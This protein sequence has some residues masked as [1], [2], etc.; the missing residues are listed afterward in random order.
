MSALVLFILRSHRARAFET[1]RQ[2][3]VLAVV[4]GLTLYMAALWPALRLANTAPA[5]AATW[6]VWINGP[7]TEEILS[8]IEQ[9]AGSDTRAVAINGAPTAA[10]GIDGTM[11]PNSRD[12]WYFST[13]NIEALDDTPWSGAFRK[14]GRIVSTGQ[15]GLDMA[16]ARDLHADIGD[17]I[18]FQVDIP[19]PDGTVERVSQTAEVAALYETTRYPSGILAELRPD[20]AALLA[21]SLGEGVVASD[22]YLTNPGGEGALLS[23]IGDALAERPVS[24]LTRS[25]YV[26]D[27]YRA[28][29]ASV[30]SG[31][32]TALIV[33]GLL[34]YFVWTLRE[35]Y[36]RFGSRQ[37]SIAILHSLGLPLPPVTRA[38]A[39]EQALIGV[40]SAAPGLV[41]ANW[42][43]RRALGYGVQA[44][45]ALPIVA[46]LCAVV[47]ATV[48]V[49]AWQSARALG[50]LPVAELLARD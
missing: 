12:V 34:V 28:A 20:V 43:V 7:L 29:D 2:V 6:D 33:A 39:T 50:R 38:L 32:M 30:D 17:T 21:E 44:E 49:T 15:C 11:R 31:Y 36:I 46:G 41:L 18:T 25:V 1:A 19:L 9:L 24:I 23:R 35:Q 27:S 10:V 3:V 42:M 14:S 26:A 4:L 8:E 48:V 47:L 40:F 45:I 16:T 37:R 5:D 22:V 13:D